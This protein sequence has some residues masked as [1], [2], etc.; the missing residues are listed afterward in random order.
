MTPSTSSYY[1]FLFKLLILAFAFDQ[2]SLIAAD[3]DLWGHLK[4][5]QQAWL[6]KSLPETD[7]YSYTAQ[8]LPWINHEW[9]SEIL[10]YLIYAS[11]GSTGLLIFK[12]ALGLFILQLL[13]SLYFS[14]ESN[15][16]IYIVYFMLITS[17]M[18]P[19]FMSRPHL[20]TFLFLTLLV[21]L[22]QKFFDGNRKA[23]AWAPA[24]M[25]V[26][27]NSHGGVVAG[28]GIFGAV[29]AIEWVRCLFTKEKHGNQLLGFFLL[30]C[31][32]LLI[33][34]YGYKLWTFF[35][36]TLSV[37][38]AI[39]EWNPVP[40][41]G[42]AHWHFK[43]LAGLF[44]L[45][46]FLPGRK[47]LWEI[48]IISLAILYAFLHQRHTVLA[49][50]VMTPYLPLKFAELAKRIPIRRNVNWSPPV[51]VVLKMSLVALTLF[52]IFMG[53]SKNRANDFK[54]LV[55]PGFYPTYAAQFMLANGISGNLLTPF[56][57][58]E[59][60]IWKLPDSRVSIDGRFRTVYPEKIIQQH[61]AFTRGQPLGKELLENY[62]TE[63][64][65]VRKSDPNR[66]A[67]DKEIRWLKI[68]EDPI[69]KIYIGKSSP[70][71][72][73]EEKFMNQTLFDPPDPPPFSFPG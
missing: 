73:I 59:Y 22:L 8:G 5:G 37:P 1:P 35:F 64:V 31:L 16:F 33:N 27:A 15:P 63:I 49:V 50:I 44:V 10:Y 3:P 19:G 51:H 9:L 2:F 38:R 20:M 61:E 43:I 65:V 26:W 60:F 72:P 21:V 56:D 48:L 67:M 52:H 32:A 57:W 30:S 46:L 70:P 12:M 68:Y 58:G 7:P 24:L 53:F 14:K 62:P 6:Q 36:Q 39:S 55:E 41:I 66:I 13:S 45:S 34:P 17:V 71:G 4:F 18:A 11:L 47:R 28:I 29:T 54:I 69:A 42:T 23:L 25:L 40:L